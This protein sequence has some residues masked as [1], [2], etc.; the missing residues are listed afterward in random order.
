MLYQFSLVSLVL[1]RLPKTVEIKESLIHV[2]E[3][4]T[5]TLELL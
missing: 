5:D 1:V 2:R 3:L 4:V